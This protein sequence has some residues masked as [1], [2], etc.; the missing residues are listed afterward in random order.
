MTLAGAEMSLEKR[1]MSFSQE[2]PQ[3]IRN[4]RPTQTLPFW[5]IAIIPSFHMACSDFGV[6]TSGL[7]LAALRFLSTI[8]TN[9]TLTRLILI[10]LNGMT[11][12]FTKNRM[13]KN[14]N[15]KAQMKIKIAGNKSIKKN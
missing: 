10:G 1:P 14:G 3:L 15:L 9:T 5:P 2:H 11:L 13:G 8:R 4:L 6:P 12:A 7:G